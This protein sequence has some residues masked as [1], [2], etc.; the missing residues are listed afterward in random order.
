MSRS[1][2]SSLITAVSDC[3]LM[4]DTTFGA[5][6]ANAESSLGR[7]VDTTARIAARAAVEEAGTKSSAAFRT[8]VLMLEAAL[9]LI[10]FLTSGRRSVKR[11]RAM[12]TF[13]FFS[14]KPN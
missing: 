8:I 6:A 10:S 14:S 1:E 3:V 13:C 5:T 12:T 2:I 7:A 4:L 11:S 9:A